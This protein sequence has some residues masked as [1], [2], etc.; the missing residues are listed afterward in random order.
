MLENN[1]KKEIVS[2]LQSSFSEAQ[3]NGGLP[4]HLITTHDI[5]ST[6]ERTKNPEHGDISSTLPLRLAKPLKMSPMAIAQAIIRE[7]R[8]HGNSIRNI[9]PAIPGFINFHISTK[10]YAAQV[11]KIIEAGNKFGNLKIGLGKSVQ[12]EFGSN[13]PTGPLHVG[14]GRGVVFGSTLANV[15]EAAGYRVH[16]EYY[17]NDHGKQ[18]EMFGKSILANYLTNLGTPTMVPNDG[19]KG[20]YIGE[21]ATELI[22]TIGDSLLSL[23]QEQSLKRS[24]EFGLN[25]MLSGIKEDLEKLNIHY[26]EWFSER[27]LFTSGKYKKSMDILQDNRHTNFEDGALWFASTKLGEDKDNVLVRKN[28][29]PTYFASDIAYHYDKFAVRNFD[30]VIVVWGADHQGHISRMK[31]AME[32][33]NIDPDRLTILITQIVTFKQGDESVKLSKRSGNISLLSELIS[34]VGADVCRYFFLSHSS[35]SQ[36]EFD[37][38]LAKQQSN[39]NPVYYIQYAYARAHNILEM[40]NQQNLNF[41]NG[42]VSYLNAAPEQKLIKSMI[43]FPEIIDLAS[44]SLEPHHLPY[45]SMELA[46]A[47][48]GFYD[49]CRVISDSEDE[50]DVTMARLKLVDASK[51]VLSRC[52]NLMGMRS[53]TSM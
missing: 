39:E 35:K 1:I 4:D 48:H 36:M 20:E 50:I 41:A 44:Q 5:E 30:R 27:S 42:D 49:R 25:E 37:L 43:K 2:L 29:S 51:L 21:L 46:T 13:N 10:W 45:Y 3:K 12:L 14:H 31:A 17:I 11:N 9:V 47:F 23:D 19:Y 6:I 28:G 40:A 22:D 18:I 52:L 32:A 53:P 7:I 24:T 26:D 16:R 33:L 15:L 8:P 34:D 38:E